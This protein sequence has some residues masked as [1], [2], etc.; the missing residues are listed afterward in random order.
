M[1]TLDPKKC[2]Q[3]YAFITYLVHRLESIEGPLCSDKAALQRV[4]YTLQEMYSLPLG[5]DF[6]LYTYG[7]YSTDLTGDMEYTHYL[8]GI[9]EYYA[10]GDSA[11]GSTVLKAGEKAGDFIREAQD[12]LKEH[13]VAPLDETLAKIGGFASYELD[14][15]ATLHMI[16]R[17]LDDRERNRNVLVLKLKEI[18]PWANTHI[19]VKMLQFLVDQKKILINE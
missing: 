5:Y 15:L 2:F 10:S 19:V 17:E 4:I 13:K 1:L 9:K 6:S 18:K 11:A 16:Y 12:F 8:G 3:Q 14:I 7:P